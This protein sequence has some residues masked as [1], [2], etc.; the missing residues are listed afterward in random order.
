[1]TAWVDFHLKLTTRGGGESP[2]FHWL[3][4]DKF[5]VKDGC[6]MQ[7]ISR[8]LLDAQVVPFQEVSAIQLSAEHSLD[9]VINALVLGEHHKA[10]QQLLAL[11]VTYDLDR[12]LD[13]LWL[14]LQI[15]WQRNHRMWF[16][17]LLSVFVQ[18]APEQD[19]RC[20]HVLIQMAQWRGQSI[21]PLGH[22]ADMPLSDGEFPHLD[23][24]ILHSWCLTSRVNKVLSRLHNLQLMPSCEVVRLEAFQYIAMNNWQ[25]AESLLLSHFQKFAHR[26][27]F[28]ELLVKCLFHLQ[29]GEACIPVLKHCLPLH[30]GREGLLLDWLVKSRLLQRQPA[31]CLRLKLIERLSLFNGELI[32][33]A[34]TLLPTY[35]M[36]G[37][38][39][40]LQYIHHSVSAHPETYINMHSNWMMILSSRPS[41]LYPVAI[42]NYLK[43]L[44]PQVIKHLPAFQLGSNAGNKL[45]IGWICGDIGN[46]PVCRFLLSWLTA[47][48]SELR[49]S[50]LIISTFPPHGDAN[51]RFQALDNVKFV[52]ISHHRDAHAQ[53]A[54]IQ[55][56]Q[57]DIALD[58]N[59][60]TGYN[61]ASI[62]IR[63]IAPVQVNYLAYH[64][65]TGIPAMDYWLVDETVVSPQPQTEWHSEK[66][67]RLPRPFLAWQPAS[68]LAEATLDVL[69]SMWTVEDGIRFG[70]FNNFR[71]ISLEVL[72]VWSSL[73]N[74]LPKAQLVLKAFAS[75]DSA[76]EE[77]VKRRLKRV[78]FTKEQ[79]IW[80]PYTAGPRAHLEQYAQI[81]VALD[82]FPNTGCTTTCEALWMGV[83]VITLE[84]DHYV[85]RMAS[86]VLR[87]AGL[88]DWIA[89]SE[90][91]Y[92]ALAFAQADSKRLMW[93][94]RNRRHWREVVANSPLG[95]A[96]DLMRHL[97]LSFEQ[98]RAVTVETPD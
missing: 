24:C 91:E 15:A 53:T 79:L 72:T 86:S 58:L 31:I 74:R 93:L 40:W 68:H 43:V 17:R 20:K 54:L 9:K 52:D 82:S 34:D 27:E 81:D 69:P 1:M 51:E 76:T 67:W 49:H 70:C 50:H 48:A 80:L 16:S 3:V 25:A 77:L 46:H 10:H 62:F 29:R 7:S 23:L 60:W 33:P 84:G 75:E 83:P 44:E 57:L 64:A 28:A 14:Q 45:R 59:G 22:I 66:L 85:S 4:F 12:Q 2:P 41:S 73:L 39:D 92:L 26:W 38:S 78:G 94:R 36:L 96:R 6:R 55:Q 90:E 8:C 61:V 18:K 30:R 65:S 98:M 19:F 63:R 42:Q 35:E 87:G 37:R 89:R 88:E 5:R 21:T 97:E 11:D 95:D 47:S 56:M 13:R 32:S 71:K